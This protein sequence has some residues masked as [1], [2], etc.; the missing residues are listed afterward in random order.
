MIQVDLGMIWNWNA[1]L[2]GPF[3]KELTGMHPTSEH[4]RTPTG[5]QS[6]SEPT[7]FPASDFNQNQEFI[8]AL[9]TSVSRGNV[10]KS[11]VKKNM[12]LNAQH[13][14]PTNFYQGRNVIETFIISFSVPLSKTKTG[15]PSHGKTPNSPWTLKGGPQISRTAS[16]PASS[17]EPL[18]FSTA[19]RLCSDPSVSGCVAPS[20]AWRP[21]RARRRSS[22][23]WRWGSR[24]TMEA[25]YFLD[26]TPVTPEVMPATPE[27]MDLQKHQMA[28]GVKTWKRKGTILS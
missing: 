9:S 20:W 3:D 21:S 15:K 26:S 22:S 23:A 4:S 13:L 16:A 11:K 19:A 12:W 10:S 17:R 5:L 14:C 7:N 25:L 28:K 24:S 2:G 18:A 27:A 8:A 6:Q 1:Q